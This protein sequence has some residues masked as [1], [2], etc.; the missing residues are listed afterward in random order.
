MIDSFNRA[1]GSLGTSDSGQTWTVPSGTYAIS[2]NTATPTAGSPSA[3][4]LLPYG[5]Q[6][7]CD[8]SLSITITDTGANPA[9]LVFRALNNDN[10]LGCFLAITTQQSQIYKSDGGVI[11]LLAQA[12]TTI[13]ANTPYAVRAVANGANI[14]MYVDGVLEVSYTLTGGDET[15]YT[16]ANSYTQVGMRGDVDAVFDSLTA[17]RLAPAGHASGTGAANTAKANIRAKAGHASGAGTAYS[18]TVLTNTAFAPAGH[19][20]GTGTAHQPSLSIDST[21]PAGHASGT[22]AA[23]AAKA[24]IRA[25]AGH[26]S[27]AGAANQPALDLLTKASAGHASGTGT[28]RQ[29]TISTTD[30]LG[31]P[32]LLAQLDGGRLAVEAAFGADLAADDDTWDWTDISDFVRYRERISLRHGRA[33]EAST[34]LPAMFRATLEN[35]GGEF[36]KGGQSSN[37]PYVRLNT[38]IR[39][40]IDLDG[41]GASYT[42]I[43]FGFADT[44][45]PSWDT[46]GT[47]AT[48]EV[49]AS[50]TLRR[51]AQGSAPLIS[52]FRRAMLDRV[53]VDLR[54]YWPCEE[55]A[56]AQTISSGIVDHPAMVLSGSAEFP[57]PKFSES[58][59]FA[60]SHPLPLVNFSTWRG[61][62]PR[63]TATGQVQLRFLAA[64]PRDP[65]VATS[66]IVASVFTGSTVCRWD[67]VYVAGGGGL[68]RL[69]LVDATGTRTDLSGLVDFNCDDTV[70][71]YSLELDQDGADIDWTLRTIGLGYRSSGGV[72][73]TV[74]TE[75]LTRATGVAI[76]PNGDLGDLVVGHV[77]VQDTIST[78]NDDLAAFNAYDFELVTDR[79]QR[80]CDENGVA[81]T[82]TGTSTAR[83]GPQSVA[84]LVPLLRECE[85]VDGGLLCDG[86]ANGL[87]YITGDERVNSAAA[88][89]LDAS[90]GEVGNLIPIDDD[91]RTRNKVTAKRTA[92]GEA[93]YEDEDGELG[94]A[95]VG[96]YDDSIEV[97]S[98]YVDDLVDHAS[99]RVALGTLPGYRYPNL[100]MALHH[101]PTLADEWLAASLSSRVDVTNIEDVRS[102]HPAG[103]ISLLL[104]G[105]TQ[106]LDQYQ[107][108]ITM[109]TS[110]YEPM[111][112]GLY[113]ANTGTTSEFVLRVDTD[114]STLNA[115]ASAGASSLSVATPSGPLWT[116]T[117]DDAPFDIEVGGIRVTV[118]AVSGASSP[119][120]FTVTGSTVT[121]ALTSGSTVALWRP[122][123]LGM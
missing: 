14:D 3:T 115:G 2:S 11:T 85:A 120:T 95:A 4:A 113:A 20:S 32:F 21:V 31:V 119:Q 122:V 24:N 50:G 61:T 22:G 96:I 74:T 8:L 55:P 82:I 114:G 108:D 105:Y 77:T 43:F 116:T 19:A 84:E 62:V 65:V 63:Y 49:T 51:L 73:D 101:D 83:M 6:D 80:L 56:L 16:A 112:A 1:N 66:A 103:T 70:R 57:F 41:G 58:T 90:N 79:V 7:V 28:A 87:S 34:T 121:K 117:A 37:W 29:P 17:Q 30:P 5:D 104:E 75:T 27:G 64:F 45:Q 48:V 69:D 39:V 68:L 72:L 111:R 107:W 38:P 44:W 93:T 59:A 36:S 98:I 110:P 18:P 67:I 118:T 123:G 60:C 26:A 94:T 78:F 23:G 76:C 102:Q 42:T 9:G 10:R 109:N 53:G 52:S 40:S 25:K 13:A 99:R 71:W 106:Q 46:T 97:N 91:Q 81:V 86:L 12:S 15:Q 92:G 54:A 47:D 88:L 89:T 35:T 100:T 33:D